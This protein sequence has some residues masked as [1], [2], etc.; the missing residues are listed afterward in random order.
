MHMGNSWKHEN[1]KDSE[2]KLGICDILE[3]GKKGADGILDFRSENGP[4]FK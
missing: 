4:I 2:I 3:K 1:S